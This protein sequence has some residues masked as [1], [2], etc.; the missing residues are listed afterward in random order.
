MQQ[1]TNLSQPGLKY[2][3]AWGKEIAGH[4]RAAAAEIRRHMDLELD[5]ALFGTVAVG[6]QAMALDAKAGESDK[7]DK[8][9]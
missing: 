6:L 1:S 9:R 4:R 3:D 8:G 2:L 5:L 7:G